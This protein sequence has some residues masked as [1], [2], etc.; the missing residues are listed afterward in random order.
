MRKLL[1]KKVIKKYKNQLF[2][3]ELIQFY[4]DNNYVQLRSMLWTI[5]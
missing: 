1:I 2:F 5:F 4:Y 3:I